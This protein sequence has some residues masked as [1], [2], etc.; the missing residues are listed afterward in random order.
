M[1]ESGGSVDVDFSISMTMQ[2]NDP[3]MIDASKK[4]FRRTVA[5][6]EQLW[7]PMLEINNSISHE[8]LWDPDTSWNLKDDKT[9]LMMFSQRYVGKLS[10]FQ[11]FHHFPL[12]QDA[13]TINVGP[14]YYSTKFMRLEVIG[15]KCGLSE[16]ANELFAWRFL[17]MAAYVLSKPTLS[18]STFHNA[19]ITVFIAR[20]S[21]YYFFKIISVQALVCLWN[22]SV[23]W[24]PAEDI[25]ARSNTTLTL[26]LASV[27]F[28]FVAND[29]VPKLGYL[30]SMDKFSVMCFIMLFLSGLETA[31]V[32][33]VHYWKGLTQ[34]AR[35]IDTIAVYA[36]IPI[37]LV[38]YAWEGIKCI[39]RRR[40]MKRQLTRLMKR[41]KVSSAEISLEEIKKSYGTI[42]EFLL[43]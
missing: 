36:Y 20:N 22:Y 10:N 5:E 39:F 18:G 40:V 43:R 23:F 9:G 8:E 17:D 30:T 11:D 37:Y 29:S 27:A 41:L 32:F 42:G 25:E 13:I 2:W 24:I 15:V 6:Y 38:V 12:D 34:L 33:W 26:F 3:C 19:N 4:G 31:V 16:H 7:T 21:S 35:D 14:K 1:A 28:M